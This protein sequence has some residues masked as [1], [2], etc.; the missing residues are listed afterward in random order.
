[1]KEGRIRSRKTLVSRTAQR[2]RMPEREISQEENDW[3]LPLSIEMRRKAEPTNVSNLQR[4][5]LELLRT[6]LSQ[7]AVR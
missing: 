3:F 5:Q 6:L 4:R 7:V 1:M 2:V